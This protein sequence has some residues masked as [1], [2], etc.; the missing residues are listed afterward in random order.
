M[1]TAAMVLVGLMAGLG[2]CGIGLFILL[3]VGVLSFVRLLLAGTYCA[4]EVGEGEGAEGGEDRHG[5][6]SGSAGRPALKVWVKRD[7]YVSCYCV[8]DVAGRDVTLRGCGV[9]AGREG[10]VKNLLKSEPGPF[11]Y[12][13]FVYVNGVRVQGVGRN[14]G[15]P[16]YEGVL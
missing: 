1:G 6:L 10:D 2:C 4:P 13:G 16:G 15:P 3:G 9:R 14:R 12:R 8:G 5:D 7:M 11:N